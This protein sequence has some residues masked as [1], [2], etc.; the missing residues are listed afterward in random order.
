MTLLKK[1]ASTSAG[2]DLTVLRV[3]LGVIFMMHGS[4]KAFGMFG[5]GGLE[6]TA[7]F[8][9][10]LGLEPASLMAFLAAFGEFG[11]GLLLILGL[12]TRFG[13]FLTGMVSLVAMLS[14]HISK[15]FFMSTGGYEYA[16]MLLAA[17]VAVL[18]AGAGKISVDEKISK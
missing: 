8:F 7:K 12:F 6:G 17:S 3:V 10:S 1:L 2:Y 18:I 16:L 15:G 4:Q 9:S 5:G 11:G 14:V 13:A